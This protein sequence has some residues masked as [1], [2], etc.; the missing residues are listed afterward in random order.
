MVPCN[1]GCGSQQDHMGTKVLVDTPINIIEIY[2]K[3]AHDY[4]E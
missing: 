2:A 1:K 4:L 3:S